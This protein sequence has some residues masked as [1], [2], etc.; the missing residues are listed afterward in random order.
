M[1]NAVH[2]VRKAIQ[3]ALGAINIMVYKHAIQAV[4]QTHMVVHIAQALVV[5]TTAPMIYVLPAIRILRH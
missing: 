4:E 5:H 3:L 1:I 2:L